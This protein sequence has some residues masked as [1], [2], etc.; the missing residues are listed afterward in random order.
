M[1]R[2]TIQKL[3]RTSL[4]FCCLIIL[5]TPQITSALSPEQKKVFDEGIGYYDV[6]EDL[7]DCSSKSTSLT[8]KDNI[9]KALNFFLGKGLT[10]NQAAGII[11]NLQWESGSKKLDPKSVQ[12]G[13]PGRGIAQW[14]DTDRWAQLLSYEKKKGADP[15]TIDAQIDFLWHEMTEVSPWNQS[16]PALKATTTADAATESFMNTFEK[17]G[18][19]HLA[20]RQKNAKEIA[21]TYGGTKT[22]TGAG[23]AVNCSGVAGSFTETVK[24]YAWPKYETGKTD[25]TPDYSK[26]I[27]VAA[28][29]GK[30]YV[31]SNHG[32]DCGAFVT[33]VFRDS[34]A[35]KTYN[36]KLGNVGAQ[37][38]YLADNPTKYQ[39]LPH[40]PKRASDLKL[41]DIYIAPDDSHTFIFLGKDAVFPGYNAATAS[42]GDHAP[43]ATNAAMYELESGIWY[44]P[45]FPL[46]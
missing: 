28:A 45:L 26:A 16:L 42:Q 20:E 44:R 17:P 1:K 33:R 31:G 24:K 14:T 43:S 38:K 37:H 19:P 40:G 11:G 30:D 10:I 41:G 6:E 2:C 3:I 9:E 4:L 35:D 39:E 21:D 27:D 23:G 7:G 36:D 15:L 18:I 46:N 25:E 34:G 12:D 32:V 5:I 13:G 29:S 8:G 22:P